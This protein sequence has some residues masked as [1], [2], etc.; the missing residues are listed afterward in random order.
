MNF[1]YCSS[2]CLTASF[3]RCTSSRVNV[4]AKPGWKINSLSDLASVLKKDTNNYQG[5]DLI[6]LFD[7]KVKL[8]VKKKEDLLK[9]KKDLDQKFKE[10]QLI[11]AREL[12]II[13]NLFPKSNRIFFQFSVSFEILT[14]SSC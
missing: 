11:I 8:L 2:P 1:S 6:S 3:R 13:R 9:R 12:E 10:E 5:P 14:S 7:P 4:F